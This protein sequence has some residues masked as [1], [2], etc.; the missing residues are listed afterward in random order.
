M[1]T[2]LLQPSPFQCW[3]SHYMDHPA[4]A[5]SGLTGS[6]RK[7]GCSLRNICQPAFSLVG[8]VTLHL[9]TVQV[10][11]FL[12][13]APGKPGEKL[14]WWVSH[15]MFPGLWQSSRLCV[16]SGRYPMEQNGEKWNAN[17]TPVMAA[18]SQRASQVSLSGKCWMGTLNSLWEF[19]CHLS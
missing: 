4:G 14:K 11:L 13:I 2:Q 9:Q 12:S 7:R 10:S 1:T 18:F 17:K 16:V 6:I 8:R 3:K 5:A 15:V 19:F